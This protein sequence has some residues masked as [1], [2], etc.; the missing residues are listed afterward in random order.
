MVVAAA[1]S[2]RG[3]GGWGVG[4]RVIG[5]PLADFAFCCGG[6]AVVEEHDRFCGGYHIGCLMSDP[7]LFFVHCVNRALKGFMR[8][9]V[10]VHF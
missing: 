5:W 3:R 8:R 1:E 10:A 9:R 7:H 4:T 6:G 2:G